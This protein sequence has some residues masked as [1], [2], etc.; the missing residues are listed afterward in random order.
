MILGHEDITTTMKY[1][2][3]T[4]EFLKDKAEVVEIDAETGNNVHKLDVMRLI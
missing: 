1:V 4:D 2:K 3:F